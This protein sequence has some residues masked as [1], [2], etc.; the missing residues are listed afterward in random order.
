SMFP[1][2]EESHGHVR[3]VMADGTHTFDSFEWA[4]ELM[5]RLRRP[6]PLP[7]LTAVGRERVTSER[8]GTPLFES[9]R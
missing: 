8:T 7:G 3:A 2:R 9:P 6:T 5:W 1:T 4:I